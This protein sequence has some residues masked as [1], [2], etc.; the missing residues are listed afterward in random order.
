MDAVVSKPKRA[1]LGID[2]GVT[3]AAAVWIP[4]QGLVFVGDL[5]HVRRKSGKLMACMVDPKGVADLIL[6][7]LS[8]YD[9]E[10]AVVEL[11]HTMPRQGVVTM[12]RMMESYGVIQGV[13]AGSE[14]ETHL[15]RPQEWKPAYRLHAD[16]AESLAFARRQ[17]PDWHAS[18][19]RVK[20][21]NRAEAALLA[22]Y[23][24]F[25]YT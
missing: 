10:V 13:L 18:F 8:L 6:G 11:I 25:A 7:A 5:P 12:G 16:K 23:G 2:P 20:D 1:A 19:K 14:V 22:L 9:V 21:H 4:S 17:F 3:G 24:A 15:V